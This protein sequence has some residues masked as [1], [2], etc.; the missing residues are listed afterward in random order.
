MDLRTVY[1]Q[2]KR[3]KRQKTVRNI[4]SS[5]CALILIACFLIGGRPLEQK[6]SQAFGLSKD[7]DGSE[8]VIDF[9]DVG[10]ASCSLIS[11]GEEYALVDTGH[12]DQNGIVAYNRL[13]NLGAKRVK[14]VFISH[15][16]KDHAGGLLGLLG[17]IPIENIVLSNQI[18]SEET[19]YYF[20]K[21]TT[22][23][24]EHGVNIIYPQNRQEFYLGRGKI[25]VYVPV[26]CYQSNENCSIALLSEFCS[27]K[28]LFMG[29]N[30]FAEENWLI[31]NGCD[32]DADILAVGHHGSKYAT[33]E[34]FLDKVS[35][36]AA[37]L[38][39][40]YNSYGHPT[41]EVLGRLEKRNCDYYYTFDDNKLCAVI[42]DGGFR[43]LTEQSEE[44]GE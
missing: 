34:R 6:F 23:A 28:T 31:N 30:G 20:S 35:P 27:V 16:H 13:K 26:D 22:L 32:I 5:F 41:D 4:L 36:F 12:E 25:T 14:Y 8:A 21:I 33:G 3:L 18:F 10:Q 44:K 39:F 11:S 24:V 17:N 42:Y 19:E 38:S 9:L 29:D 1:G 37:V 40:G 15:C 43:I 7:E 2:E